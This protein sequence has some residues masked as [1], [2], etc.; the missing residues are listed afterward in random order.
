MTGKPDT[1]PVKRAL[2]R[3]TAGK[4]WTCDKSLSATEPGYVD[5]D[6]RRFCHR[7][8]AALYVMTC[9]DCGDEF[10]GDPER[11]VCP[12]CYSIMVFCDPSPLVV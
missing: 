5:P 2:V 9:Q 6:G 8:A 3:T 10:I 7:H 11:D 1:E 12:N 4:C